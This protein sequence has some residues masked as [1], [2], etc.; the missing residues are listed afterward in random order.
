MRTDDTEQSCIS[1]SSTPPRSCRARFKW[2]YD[3]L[4]LLLVYILK[5]WQFAAMKTT[6]IFKLAELICSKPELLL[7]TGISKAAAARDRQQRLNFRYD[8]LC[9][10]QRLSTPIFRST[11]HCLLLFR[12]PC[13]EC[14]FLRKG[15]LL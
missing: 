4:L 12:L 13:L 9:E 7:Y 5:T 14:C 6:L 1:L 10:C 15:L 8:V 11:E 3:I 2:L